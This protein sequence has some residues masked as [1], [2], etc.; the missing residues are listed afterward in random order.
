[1]ATL[2]KVDIFRK[3]DFPWFLTGT[4]N[5]EDV[6][7]CIKAQ[8]KVEGITIAVD[9]TVPAGHVLKDKRVLFPNNAELMRSQEKEFG[10]HCREVSGKP[11]PAI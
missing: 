5:T 10:E 4:A 1:M 3:I 8:T 7:F 2:I 11:T 9:T 6:Y